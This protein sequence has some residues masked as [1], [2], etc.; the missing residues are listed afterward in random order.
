M[1]GNFGK[2]QIGKHWIGVIVLICTMEA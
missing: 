2:I 1:I